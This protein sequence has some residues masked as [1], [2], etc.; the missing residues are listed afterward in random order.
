MRNCY[1][2]AKTDGWNDA[3]TGECLALF[4]VKPDGFSLRDY[5]FP[6]GTMFIARTEAVRQVFEHAFSAS[7][8]PDELGQVKHT[9]Q[10]ALE[11]VWH[12]V[13][14]ANGFDFAVM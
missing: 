4:G 12:P 7:D 1:A 13:C 8:F 11:L 6:I 5:E 10:H 2:V 9:L 14:K 3:A